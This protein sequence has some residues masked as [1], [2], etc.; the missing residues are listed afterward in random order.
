M[1]FILNAERT[2]SVADCF[3]RYRKYLEEVGDRMPPSAHELATSDCYFNFSEHRCPHDAWLRSVTISDSGDTGEKPECVSIRVRLL[4]AYHD[5]I[6]E[7]HYPQVVRYQLGA[8][9]INQ[10]HRDW[11]YD[12]FRLSDDGLVIHEIEWSGPCETARWVIE[13]KDVFY[14]WFPVD[15]GGSLA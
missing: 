4:A 10:G 11:R 3:P 9:G 13:A 5:G 14:H 2:E 1:A 12:E 8:I 6:I 15:A 7:F